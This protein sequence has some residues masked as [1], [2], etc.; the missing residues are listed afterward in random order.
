MAIG[1]SWWL[2]VATVVVAAALGALGRRLR[3]TAHDPWMHGVG[4]AALL[5]VIWLPRPVRDLLVGGLLAWLAWFVGKEGGGVGGVIAMAIV[6]AVCWACFR[7]LPG[8]VSTALLG[9][10]ALVFAAFEVHEGA[11]HARRMKRLRALVPGESSAAEVEASGVARARDPISLPEA[12]MERDGNS[13]STP[14][15]AFHARGQQE[16]SNEGLLRIETALG[17]ALVDCRRA[18]LELEADTALRGEAA[19]QLAARLGIE[20]IKGKDYPD[21]VVFLRWLPDGTEVCV[22][23]VP[24][25]AEDAGAGSYR[26]GAKLPLFGEG[27]TLIDRSIAQV[28]RDAG[29]RVA[30]WSLWLALMVVIAVVQA[31]S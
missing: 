1:A 7:W 21:G 27:A 20:P 6:L 16:A 26:G 8:G 12:S 9:I 5:V 28:R 4:G 2:T 31:L 18:K 23:G 29:F 15:A 10:L 17:A 30:S 13:P 11:Q 19:S 3:V 24:T 25:W 14:V 22:F